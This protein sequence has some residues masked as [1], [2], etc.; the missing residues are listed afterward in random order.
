MKS[1]VKTAF[2][3]EMRQARS[4]FSAQSWDESFRHLERA[5]ILGQRYFITH[6]WTH[7]W[8][9]KVAVRKADWREIRGQIMRLVAVV[10]G[11]LFGWVPKGNTGGANVSALLPMPVPKD[12]EPYLRDYRVW[13]DVMGRLFFWSIAALV[14]AGFLFAA[15]IWAR[16]GEGRTIVSRHNGACERLLGVNG[17]EDIV[18]DPVAQ[19]AYTAGGDR[20]ALRAGGP[21]RAHIWAFSTNDAATLIDVAP[22][23]PEVFRSFGMDI[24]RDS[25]GVVRLFVVN[26]ADAYHGVEVFRV[27]SDRTLTHERTLTAPNLINPNDV[28]A[29]DAT[30]AYVTL[31][32]EAPAGGLQEVLEGILERPTG[33]VAL[34]TS[35]AM[36]IVASGL[37]M[38]NGIT[39]NSDRSE[40]YVAEM[41][42]RS[43]AVFDVDAKAQSLK[44]NRR[45]ALETNPDNITLTADGRVLV[46]AHPKLFTLALGYQRSE[47]IQSPSEIIAVDPKDGSRSPVFLDTGELMSGS[48]VALQVPGTQRLLIG[49]AFAPYALV[50]DM[51]A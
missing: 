6:V 50:C 41:V 11:Y 10:P 1:D 38:A 28:V 40:L 2:Q 48:S 16:S 24:H 23:A 15:D 13:A 22:S 21:G 3:S 32:K 17:P 7:L 51:P 18:I 8:M 44:F 47:R 39:F 26:R 45:I 43:L 5:H 31:D 4:A 35:N 30:S 46:A 25:A 36:E 42:G 12:L 14:L 49:S 27:E 19:L 29:I 33:R 37:L 9:L 34:V 20:R